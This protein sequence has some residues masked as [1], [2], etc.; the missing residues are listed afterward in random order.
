MNTFR[1]HFYLSGAIVL[2]FLMGTGNSYGQK[3]Q[4]KT[5]VP[6]SIDTKN[7]SVSVDAANCRWSHRSREQK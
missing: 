1:N 7:L 2:V 3:S 6:L 5:S 4:K